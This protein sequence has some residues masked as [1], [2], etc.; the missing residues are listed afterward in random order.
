[1][2]TQVNPANLQ[3]LAKW[4]A[5]AVQAKYPSIGDFAARSFYIPETER[6][7]KLMPHQQSILDYAFDPNHH[8]MTIVYS[9]VKKSGKTAIGSLVARWVAETWGR[10]EVYC[11]AN[12]Y[13]QAR[14]RIY[15]KA[16]DSIELD[17]AYNKKSSPWKIIE[18]DARYLPNGSL[19][20]AVSSDYKGEAGSNPTITLW[21]E[22]WASTSETSHRLW[23]ELTPVPTR[24]RSIRYVETYAGFEDE[25]DLLI[26]LYTQSVTK[27]RRLTHDDIDW[28]FPDQPPIYVNERARSFAYWDEGVEARRMPW[29]TPE[30]YAAQEETLRP[31]AFDRLHLNHWTSS[32]SSFIPVEWWDACQEELPIPT[33]NEPM[34][35][36][37]DAAVSHDCCALVGVTRHPQRVDDVAVRIVRVWTPP[38]NGKIDLDSTIKASIK[39]LALTHNV[40]QV[41]YDPYQLESIMYDLNREGVAWCKPFS[42]G[43]SR[44]VADKQLYD[45]IK[46]RHLAHIGH[47][48]LRDHIK[49]AAAKQ[50]K[51]EDTKL[52]II[53]KVQDKKI[54]GT[55]AMSMAV[56]ESKRLLL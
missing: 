37:V 17:P 38:V 35:L 54:D 15:Q 42:Q 16:I 34:V 7:L 8:F 22:L 5:P 26:Q 29:Q 21:S 48:E 50:N 14:G 49:N 27:A 45:M 52:R 11:L 2:A 13:E 6:P 36:G 33:V 46:T 56:A 32:V 3:L 18:R 4:L 39:E 51:D 55:I 30:Y 28:P 31:Q 40:V 53:K 10:S 43:E 47:S 12:D 9:T 1:M 41:A 19:L 24:D 23:D 44:M 20:R 25:S